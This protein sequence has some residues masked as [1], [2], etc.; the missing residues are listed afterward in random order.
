MLVQSLFNDERARRNVTCV[1][2]V[3][4]NGR[5]VDRGWHSVHYRVVH[6]RLLMN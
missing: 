4:V 2:E 5:D 1:G 3:V 6:Y